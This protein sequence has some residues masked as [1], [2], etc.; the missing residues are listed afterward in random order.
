MKKSMIFVLLL[1]SSLVCCGAFKLPP[2]IDA[3]DFNA[4]QTE[5]RLAAEVMKNAYLQD[6]IDKR[7]LEFV[8]AFMLGV[9]VGD[10]NRSRSNKLK[11]LPKLT[12][13]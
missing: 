4:H 3:V 7:I 1:C 11:L 9:I 5:Q 6:K 2:E 12:R 13:V 8:I 10:F